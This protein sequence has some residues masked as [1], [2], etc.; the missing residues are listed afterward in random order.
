MPNVQVVDNTDLLKNKP[1][2]TFK[3]QVSYSPVKGDDQSQQ[4]SSKKPASNV[5]DSESTK[6]SDKS[7][8]DAVDAGDDVTERQKSDAVTGCSS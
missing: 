6:D 4:A 3:P 8:A 1:Y 2:G 7:D 5:A